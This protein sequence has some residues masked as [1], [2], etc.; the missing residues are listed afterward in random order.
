[1]DN[2]EIYYHLGSYIGTF[3]LFGGVIY[4]YII[5]KQKWVLGD[6]LKLVVYSYLSGGGLVI[7]F[8]GLNYVMFNYKLLPS[9]FGS[10]T[11]AERMALISI[12]SF[13]GLV[14]IGNFAVEFIKGKKRTKKSVGKIPKTRRPDGEKNG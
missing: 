6:A 3:I 9:Y 14:F 11:D 2:F 7:I 1:M 4:R 10:F 12:G 8:K 13:S 5:K